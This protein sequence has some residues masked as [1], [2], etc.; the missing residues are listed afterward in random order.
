LTSSTWAAPFAL[1]TIDELIPTLAP[2]SAGAALIAAGMRINLIGRAGGVTVAGRVVDPADAGS[3]VL[4]GAPIPVRTLPISGPTLLPRKFAVIVTMTN[5]V[6]SFTSAER[7]IRQ[8]L[9]EAVALRLDT[10]LFSTTAA[11]TSRP[12]GLLNNVVAVTAAAAGSEA[13]ALDIGNL[14]SA[15]S[16]A[17]GG[18]SPFFVCNPAQACALKLRSGPNFDFPVHASSTLAAGTVVCVEAGSFVSGFSAVPEI[19]VTSG[20]TLHAEDTTPLPIVADSTKATPVRAIFQTDCSA[21][22]MILRC[23][24]GM[25]ASGHIQLV[26]SMTW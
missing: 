21:I 17:G 2:L 3:F 11:S 23:S 18:Q 1:A 7:V 19:V 15:I 25:R 12:A 5:E 24:G 4:E 9:S 8:L 20:G 14:I 6:A 22:R 26:N 16:A 10:E 13:M